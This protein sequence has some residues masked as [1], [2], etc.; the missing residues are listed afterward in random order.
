MEIVYTPNET[1]LN[2]MVGFPQSRPKQIFPKSEG[3]QLHGMNSVKIF[4]FPQY[5]SVTAAVYSVITEL[6]F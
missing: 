4:K 3:I 5:F 6:F 1:N 2:H